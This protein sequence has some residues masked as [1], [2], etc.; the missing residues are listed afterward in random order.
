M[1]VGYIAACAGFAL[2]PLKEEQ[3]I[4]LLPKGKGSLAW[5]LTPHKTGSF[6]IVVTD[7]L[8]TRVFGVTVTNV[9]GL[10]TLQAQLLSVVGGLFGPIFTIPWWLDKWQ[11]RKEKAKPAA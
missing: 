7:I 9:F 11:R 10:N 8:D 3:K 5:I 1:R 4:E 2:S 6:Q